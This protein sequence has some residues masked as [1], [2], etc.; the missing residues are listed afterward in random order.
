MTAA[1]ITVLIM[2]ACAGFCWMLCAAAGDADR[3]EEEKWARR[4]QK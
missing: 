2:L 3:R 4:N 1:I